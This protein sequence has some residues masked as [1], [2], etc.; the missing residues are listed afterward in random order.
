MPLLTAEVLFGFPE[1]WSDMD[2][3]ETDLFWLQMNLPINLFIECF[4]LENRLKNTHRSLPEQR[5]ISLNVLF[6]Q[7]NRPNPSP[8]AADPLIG[9]VRTSFWL[10]LWINHHVRWGFFCLW[11]KEFR[12][13]TSP[14]W[15]ADL[16]N[17]NKPI[18]RCSQLDEHADWINYFTQLFLGRVI[19]SDSA[20]EDLGPKNNYLMQNCVLNGGNGK[21]HRLFRGQTLTPRWL[22]N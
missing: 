2:Q 8:Q 17:P 12:N 18:E 1:M 6:C 7:N 9:E 13:F 5:V 15:L 14:H 11:I 21:I 4:V 10:K 20:D 19:A 16:C 3:A 22:T